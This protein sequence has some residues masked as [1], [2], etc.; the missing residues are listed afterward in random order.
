M[1]TVSAPVGSGTVISSDLKTWIC[2]THGNSRTFGWFSRARSRSR[3]VLN[4]HDDHGVRARWQRHRDFVVETFAEQSAAERRIHADVVGRHVE[5]V[6]PDEPIPAQGA[7]GMLE[8]NPGAEVDPV[9]IPAC[10]AGRRAGIDDEHPL[11]TFAEEP[12]APVDFVQTLLAVGVFGIFGAV[13]LGGG[14]RYGDGD[15]RPLLEPQPVKF[16]A[17]P[18]GPFRGDVLGTGGRGRA[19]S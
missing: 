1:I 9:V 4:G 7:R 16:V 3:P 14:F 13:A 15:A 12:D 18:L 11:E 8:L 5:F 2:R 17:Q 10:A 6:W 19:V